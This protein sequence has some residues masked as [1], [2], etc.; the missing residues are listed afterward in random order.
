MS[1]FLAGSWISWTVWLVA[2][3]FLR[4][5]AGPI[6]V[7]VMDFRVA[8]TSHRSVQSA[9]DFTAALQATLSTTADVE[10]VERERIALAA[11]EIGLLGQGI[12]EPSEAAR[13]GRW[14]GA[15]WA[16]F[17]SFRTNSPSKVRVLALEVVDL[18]R[19][20]P[21]AR[22]NLTMS[23]A[24]GKVP[25]VWSTD[26]VAATA[27]FIDRW[28]ASLAATVASES[29]RPVVALLAQSEW[30]VAGDFETAEQALASV[31]SQLGVRYHRLEPG[32]E[33]LFESEAYLTGWTR[34]YNHRSPMPADLLLFAH[35]WFPERIRITAWD[36]GGKSSE[37]EFGLKDPA[38]SAARFA[39][40]LPRILTDATNS[41]VAADR[42]AL[43]RDIVARAASTGM[44]L[45]PPSYLG[46]ARSRRTWTQGCTVLDVALQLAPEDRGIRE[47][48]TRQRWAPYLASDH[49]RPFH[50]RRRALEAWSDLVARHGPVLSGGKELRFADPSTERPASVIVRLMG[51]LDS[52]LWN[53]EGREENR[54]PDDI[55][56]R[57]VR[58]WDRRLMASFLAV[59]PR[60]LQGSEWR[61][62]A[63]PM[64]WILMRDRAGRPPER[65]EALARVE[66]LRRIWPEA[67]RAGRFT[68]NQ[69]E[70]SLTDL[71][72][73]AGLAGQ[74]EGLLAPLRKVPD[75]VPGS[76]V[77]THR[78]TLLLPPLAL[79]DEGL[80][81]RWFAIG[82]PPAKTVAPASAAGL[83]R[84]PPRTRVESISGA[85]HHDG[86]LWIS[87]RAQESAAEA[88]TGRQPDTELAGNGVE[89][90]QRVWR[91]D[92]GGS[93]A[94]AVP[95]PKSVS[96]G[97]PFRQR[98]G[99]L[100][101]FANHQWWRWTGQEWVAADAPRPGVAMQPSLRLWN[102][103]VQGLSADGSYTNLVPE[104][105]WPEVQVN[106][107][108]FRRPFA[109]E[110]MMH[111]LDLKTLTRIIRVLESR[112]T[113][114]V[115][116]GPWGIGEITAFLEDGSTIWIGTSDGIV[117][118]YD[119]PSR[120]HLRAVRFSSAI[121]T[122][123][124]GSGALWVLLHGVDPERSPN[125]VAFR[126]DPDRLPP[127]PPEWG[128]ESKPAAGLT[129]E[130]NASLALFSGHPEK[131][132]RTMESVP[133]G[134]RTPMG[135]LFLVAA[136]EDLGPA[137]RADMEA[138]RRELR[139]RFPGSVSEKAMMTARRGVTPPGA[140][141]AI[142][143]PEE[144]ADFVMSMVDRDGDGFIDV[145]EWEITASAGQRLL[146]DSILVWGQAVP[147]DTNSLPARLWSRVHE[148]RGFRVAGTKTHRLSHAD[149][150]RTFREQR[151]LHPSFRPRTAATNLPSATGR[152]P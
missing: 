106:R 109:E 102:G 58:E 71:F 117:A 2:F 82:S 124:R 64:A 142:R 56:G 122:I 48:W 130:E 88:P 99:V 133:S 116:V 25:L 100:E 121:Q 15:E 103:I 144:R 79:L 129:S 135:W 7:A 92:G 54:V 55:G 87:G 96:E 134:L 138:A 80:Q 39:T 119:R 38:D 60:L 12:V 51:E 127:A 110:A 74:Q 112:P 118:S 139:T 5:T 69:V 43:A 145:A 17:G 34:H 150:I 108:F 59:L 136:L 62:D 3:G 63:A 6:R 95:T 104:A 93:V 61:E 151:G 21:W 19:A 9:V 131:A 98:D 76:A 107:P 94:V 8:E 28:L 68:T 67:M 141:T 10:W 114:P 66:A 24:T 26:D 50:F 84:F 16:L 75:K 143:T 27:S 81:D 20:I 72:A 78:P 32:P 123:R 101:L 137:R 33:T 73:K 128:R 4:A 13:A 140:P 44:I 126:L 52:D 1:R 105:L 146:P 29:K 18:N 45:R 125:R 37:F 57:V 47:A 11:R 83:I 41:A 90:L 86:A 91:I 70:S 35:T 31:C 77:P 113:S 147:G 42:S 36:R 46:D 49:S 85:V 40:W 149:L 115:V 132:A 53:E 148:N 30:D 23:A 111:E 22:T 89:E 152:Q 65:P 14:A 120:R 97:D